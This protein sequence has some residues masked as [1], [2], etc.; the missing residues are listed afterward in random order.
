MFEE[1]AL[2]FWEMF[3]FEVEWCLRIFACLIALGGLLFWKDAWR[4]E[5]VRIYSVDLFGDLPKN[6]EQL[7]PLGQLLLP[8]GQKSFLLP[9]KLQSKF[10]NSLNKFYLKILIERSVIN[11]SPESVQAHM[12]EGLV[13]MFKDWQKKE[14]ENANELANSAPDR[15]SKYTEDE[16]QIFLEFRDRMRDK[17]REETWQQFSDNIYC[18]YLNGYVWD[19]KIAE[20]KLLGMVV[21]FYPY[22]I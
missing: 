19:L 1:I 18:R 16:L 21:L 22:K 15:K 2:L 3:E 4:R 14:E 10:Q 17:I 8:K 20:E 11:F 9:K 5:S 6:W 7:E 12:T 13:D